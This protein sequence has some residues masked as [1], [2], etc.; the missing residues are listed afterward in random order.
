VIWTSSIT[1]YCLFLNLSAGWGISR[2]TIDLGDAHQ[3]PM[4]NLTSDIVSRL[5]TVH[6]SFAAEEAQLADR[7]GWQRRLDQ[8][9]ASIL[10]IPSQIMLLAR[11]FREFRLPLVKGKT[12]RGIA[13]PPNV[14]QLELYARRLTTE[15]DAFLERRHHR[16][17]V[18][19]LSADAGVIATI[20][21]ADSNQGGS[22][23]VKIAGPGDQQQV[24]DILKAA[25]QKYG[26]WIYVR[27]SV[28]VFEGSKVHLCKSARRLEWT[29]TQ[30]LL[31]AADVI[32]EV[33]EARSRNA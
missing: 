4:P 25:Q 7:S 28:I 24:H 13:D 30:A 31:D 29:E 18:D 14:R 27:R 32:A 19:V 10:K 9:V 5:A 15:L 16:H 8:E 20:K 26:Q 2:S 3:M 6:R 23:I 22:P 11:E 17:R 1:P 21:L 12:P 33:A